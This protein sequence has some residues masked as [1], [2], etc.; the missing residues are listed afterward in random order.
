MDDRIR[1]V[2]RNGLLANEKSSIAGW[3]CALGQEIRRFQTS[4]AVFGVTSESVRATFERA[5]LGVGSPV[6][7]ARMLWE[8]W[9]RFET[10]AVESLLA[11]GAGARRELEKA[12]KRLRQIFLDGLR[13]L[14]WVKNWIVMGLRFFERSDGLGWSRGELKRVYNVLH[15][16]ELRIRTEGLE[17]LLDELHEM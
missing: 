14:P 17:D 16:R 13:F 10:E 1:T 9:F 5:L 4:G 2:M 3:A 12:S 8:M 7:H 6:A 15:E 11:N